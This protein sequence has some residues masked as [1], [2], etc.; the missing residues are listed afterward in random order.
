M[1]FSLTTMLTI[2]FFTLGLIIGSFLNVVICRMNTARTFGGRS[3]CMSCKNCLSWYELIPVFSFLG[4]K[5]RCRNCKTKISIQYP[6][7]ELITG[8]VFALILLKFQN[9]FFVDIGMFTA[10]YIY[11]A[12]MF[13]ILMVVVVYDLRHKIIP[14]TL[15]LV[16]GI[17]AFLGL[18]VFSVN[19]FS[20]FTYVSLRVPTVLQ[21][22]SGPI[23]AAPFYLLWLVS[24]GRWMGLGDAKLALGLGWFLGLSAALSALVLSFWAGTIVGVGLIILSKIYNWGYGMKSEIP[25]APYLVFGTLVAFIFELNLFNFI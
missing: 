10:V 15:S 3:A 6:L 11:Y 12:V 8:L 21:F 7:V 14:D 25:F 4:L 16:F 24:N 23:A 17:L 1:I 9:I 20:E 13:S 2:I 5:G 19:P 22:L 18:F